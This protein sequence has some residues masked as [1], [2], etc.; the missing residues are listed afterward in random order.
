MIA[1]G[2]NL[3]LRRSS[4]AALKK[5]NPPPKRMI[6]AECKRLFRAERRTC[7]VWP[8]LDASV[9][10]ARQPRGP[11]GTVPSPFRTPAMLPLVVVLRVCAF[12]YFVT[13]SS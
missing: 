3:Y 8:W 6:M 1:L 4:R 5:M 7:K 2:R 13:D 10:G 11:R 9:E 12:P